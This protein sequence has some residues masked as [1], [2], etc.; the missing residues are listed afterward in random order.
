MLPD[1]R[2]RSF[3]EANIDLPGNAGGWAVVSIGEP[4]T[5]PPLGFNSLNPLHL[6]LE[7]HDI[8]EPLTLGNRTFQTPKL[9]HVEMLVDFARM[10]RGARLVYCHCVAG[11]SRSTAAAYILRTF[12]SGPGSEADCLID[13]YA[14][15]PQAWP[16]ERMVE[17]ADEVLD[18]G[19]ALS[20]AL[21]AHQS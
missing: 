21:R 19:G 7:F 2:A 14:D 20:A 16:N 12:W 15:R 1:V 10:A 17:L 6:R 13:V 11:I 3:P 8:V 5:D 9:E 18:R 4:G